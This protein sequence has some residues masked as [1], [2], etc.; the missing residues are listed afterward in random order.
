MRREVTPSLL[1]RRRRGGGGGGGWQHTCLTRFGQPLCGP[2]PIR[3]ATGRGGA[4]VQKGHRRAPAGGRPLRCRRGLAVLHD[5]QQAST[6]SAVAL[7]P[8]SGGSSSPPRLQAADGQ[9]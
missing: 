7:Q 9:A 4:A 3:L 1:L 2:K 5:D 6:A 8:S